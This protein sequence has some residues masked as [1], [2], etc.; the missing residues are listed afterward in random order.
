MGARNAHIAKYTAEYQRLFPSSRILVISFK[1]TYVLSHSHDNLRPAAE[2]IHA[3]AVA[4]KREG[5][6]DEARMLIHMFSNGGAGT[7]RHLLETVRELRDPNGKPNGHLTVPRHVFISDSAPGYFHWMNAYSAMA[8]NFPRWVRPLVHV[9]II[10]GWVLYILPGRPT[11]FENNAHGC[12]EADFLAQQTRRLYLYGNK[13]IMV[14]PSDIEDDAATVKKMVE[15]GKVR[16]R[17]P[18]VSLELFEGSSHVSHARTDF[19]RY[20]T[21]VE[22]AWK[23]RAIDSRRVE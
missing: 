20:W 1:W 2:I 19:K 3:E 9:W 8:S 11:W 21:A 18:V 10:I 6:E 13:D 15:G 12:R 7:M 17:G 5:K 14:D 23:R 22:G 4:A 16:G